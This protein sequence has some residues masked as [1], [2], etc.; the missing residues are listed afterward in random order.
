MSICRLILFDLDGVTINTEHLYARAETRL[1]DEYGVTIPDNDWKLFRGCSEETF[2]TLSMDR[3]EIKEERSVFM[4]KGR[5]LILKEFEKKLDFMPGFK[6]LI[7]K[8]NNYYKIG[9]VTA[10]PEHM[11][12]WLDKKLHLCSFFE[13]VVYGGMS[14]NSKPHPDP[15]QLCMKK[16]NILPENTMIIEDSVHGIQSGL[17]A[18]ARVVALTGSV[19]VEDMPQAHVIINSLNEIDE[20]FIISLFS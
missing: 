1:F 7:K 18:G 8:I 19:D 13:H 10:T 3:Y 9:L 11:F 5:N 12:N 6:G 14:K 2:Y 15:Y 16:F 20:K 4:K 17:S